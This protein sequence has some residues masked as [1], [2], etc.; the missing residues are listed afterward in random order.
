MTELG[1]NVDSDSMALEPELQKN[2]ID[3]LFLPA[4]KA[5]L[6]ESA[7][8]RCGGS[9]AE[10]VSRGL[11]NSNSNTSV[12]SDSLAAVVEAM[13]HL[14]RENE[15]LAMF[16]HFRFVLSAFG[17][18]APF[19]GENYKAILPN[20]LAW[21]QLNPRKVKVD[22]G[23][24]FFVRGAGPLGEWK[25]MTF[26]KEEFMTFAGE[27][28]GGEATLSKPMDMAL[29]RFGGLHGKNKSPGV[30]EASKV[31]FYNDVKAP[32]TMSEPGYNGSVADEWSPA[33]T[34]STV[35]H[36]DGHYMSK[37][38]RYESRMREHHSTQFTMRLEVR[39]A[40]ADVHGTLLDKLQSN[41]RS[42]NDMGAFVHIQNHVY[43]GYVRNVLKVTGRI[44]EYLESG[45][46]LENVS[47]LALAVY[48]MNSLF[49]P[50]NPSSTCAK[51]FV[52]ENR[53]PN[54]RLCF[55]SGG[56]YWL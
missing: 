34:R 6:P 4:C 5:V 37:R 21:D 9:Y 53:C 1:L 8:N 17:F 50:G 28:V 44:I 19:N 54:N 20:M 30:G 16:R 51:N 14:V 33:K 7:Y 26:L 35:F 22:V 3:K 32:F 2:F 49:H 11:F 46:T 38:K 15:S 56:V 36:T 47:G 18:K 31:I 39:V 24:N 52:A 40:A 41:I 43:F 45:L 42:L 10:S 23:V 48:M 27:L 13:R 55:L 29:G 12:S 25:V